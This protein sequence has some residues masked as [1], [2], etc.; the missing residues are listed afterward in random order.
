MKTLQ[1]NR[2]N[3]FNLFS[4]AA[5]AAVMAAIAVAASVVFVSVVNEHGA[6]SQP[7]E[8]DVKGDLFATIESQA[9]TAAASFSPRSSTLEKFD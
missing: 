5:S 1:F 4:V 9:D 8:H 2:L 6:S 7:P 3:G